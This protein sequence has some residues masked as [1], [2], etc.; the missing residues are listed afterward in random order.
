MVNF[1][2]KCIEPKIIVKL[3]NKEKEGFCLRPDFHHKCIQNKN[4]CLLTDPKGNL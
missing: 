1:A 2:L 4:I 3:E